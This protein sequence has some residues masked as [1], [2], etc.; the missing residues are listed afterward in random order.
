MAILGA[1]VKQGPEVKAPTTPLKK[2][3]DLTGPQNMPTVCPELSKAK[4][5]GLSDFSELREQQE[6]RTVTQHSNKSS[7][8]RE[9][10]KRRGSRG[11][12]PRGGES[13]KG[14]WTMEIWSGEMIR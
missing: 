5:R 8:E 1:M 6:D 11:A 14:S 7:K 4:V 9:Q 3:V 12:T 2:S 10:E 13:E